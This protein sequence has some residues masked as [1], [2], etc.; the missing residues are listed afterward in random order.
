MEDNRSLA[1]LIKDC[2][3]LDLELKEIIK[4]FLRKMKG[5]TK[6]GEQK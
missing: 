3:V 2:E 6:N 1:Q 4:N 5:E